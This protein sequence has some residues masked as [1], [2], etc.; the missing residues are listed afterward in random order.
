MIGE[1]LLS[2]SFT[3]NVSSTSRMHVYY[4][5]LAAQSS[6][7]TYINIDMLV[8]NNVFTHYANALSYY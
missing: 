1:F 8:Y 4:Y 2:Q 7:H 5:Q 6:L 3:P